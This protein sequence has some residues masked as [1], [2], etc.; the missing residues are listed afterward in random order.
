MAKLNQ[1][2]TADPKPLCSSCEKLVDWA[3][4]PR[5]LGEKEQVIW[6]PTPD[7]LTASMPHCCFCEF[8]GSLVNKE[9]FTPQDK[10]HFIIELQRSTPHATMV[11]C[12]VDGEFEEDKQFYPYTDIMGSNCRGTDVGHML[13]TFFA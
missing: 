4:S 10:V 6:H 7:D 2:Q 3:R 11:D 1:L 9:S 8:M 5:S 12:L 13:T